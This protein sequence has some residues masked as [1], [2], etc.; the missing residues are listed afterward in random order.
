MRKNI[1]KPMIVVNDHTDM[2]MDGIGF[3]LGDGVVREFGSCVNNF[4]SWNVELRRNLFDWELEQWN[5]FRSLIDGFMVCDNLEDAVI[6]ESTTS[7]AYSTNQY[8]REFLKISS[9]FH[10]NWRLVWY[11]QELKCFT[12]NSS[13]AKLQSE[14]LLYDFWKPGDKVWKMSFC[15]I[16]WSLWLTRNDMIF[17]GLRFDVGQKALAPC[18][19][20]TIKSKAGNRWVKPL[21]GQVKFDVNGST[22][23]KPRPAGIGGILRDHNEEVLIVFSKSI[24]VADSNFAELMAIRESFLLFLTSPWLNSKMLIIE[25]DSTN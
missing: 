21:K 14:Q 8:C 12:G 10:H 9:N 3:L 18:P 2:L 13:I 11:H 15:A 20:N 19:V 23:G 25:S 5:N 6:W 16:L 7:G 17:K 24:D 22:Q 1:M 4:W